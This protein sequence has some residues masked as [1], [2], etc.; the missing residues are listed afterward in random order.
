MRS[1]PSA[2]HLHQGQRIFGHVG[3]DR[4]GV[5]HFCDV[6]DAA[7]DAVGDARRPAGATR[8]L[9]R[10]VV[11]DLDGE[12]ARRAAHDRGE[13]VALVV[14]Q[15]ECHAEAVAKRVVSRPVRVV[16]P[17]R[18]NGGRSSASVLAAGPCP[19]MMSRRQSSSAG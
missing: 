10:G 6:A 12:D 14:A 7:Q 19:T 13:L 4:A 8:D 1:R 15:A 3:R 9:V 18:V 5:A 2:V 16:A 17:T 11:V